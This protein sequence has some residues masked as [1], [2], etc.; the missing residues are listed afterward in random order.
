M[1]QLIFMELYQE[2]VESTH[3]SML[4]TTLENSP[5]NQ[6]K[7]CVSLQQLAGISKDSAHFKKNPC[8]LLEDNT[9]LYSLSYLVGMEIIQPA[10][11]VGS[12]PAWY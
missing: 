1:V 4:L 6:G 5:K 3:R 2:S 9:E 10:L 8:L 12:I 7:S 11:N